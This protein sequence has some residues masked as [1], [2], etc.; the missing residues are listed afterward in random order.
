MEINKIKNTLLLGAIVLLLLG[1]IFM[2]VSDF[3]EGE[4][5]VIGEDK[6]NLQITGIIFLWLSFIII[7]SVLD[8]KKLLWFFKNLT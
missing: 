2:T 8:S 1:T 4:F 7:I 5:Q 6:K 3:A